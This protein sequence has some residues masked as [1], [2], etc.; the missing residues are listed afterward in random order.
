MPGSY[1]IEDVHT[2]LLK[3]KCTLLS[4]YVNAKTKIKI[5]CACGHDRVSILKNILYY[6]QFLCKYCTDLNDWVIK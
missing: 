4:E 3:H 2:I 5:R 6:K 1:K